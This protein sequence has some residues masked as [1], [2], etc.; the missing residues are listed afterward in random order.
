MAESFVAAPATNKF[1]R[2]EA[3]RS[4]RFGNLFFHGNAGGNILRIS[5]GGSVLTLRAISWRDL[6][7][8]REDGG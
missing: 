7:Y 2:L 6:C 4:D 5:K 3:Q 1:K 8:E